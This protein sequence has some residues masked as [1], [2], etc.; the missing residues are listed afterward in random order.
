MNKKKMNGCQWNEIVLR[1][2]TLNTSFNTF[3]L[4]VVV[5]SLMAMNLNVG[6]LSEK[7]SSF[8]MVVCTAQ[9][10]LLAHLFFYEDAN[11]KCNTNF[12][13]IYF[14]RGFAGIAYPGI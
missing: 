13:R 6:A 7:C 8:E 5:S 1:A 9:I 14:Y 4:V 2:S 10:L 11:G 3:F 12:I